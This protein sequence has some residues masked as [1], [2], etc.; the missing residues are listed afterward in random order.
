[1]IGDHRRDS[2]GLDFLGK[3]VHAEREHVHKSAQ[4]INPGWEWHRRQRSL[5]QRRRRLISGSVSRVTL[6][7]RVMAY[8]ISGNGIEGRSRCAV[9]ANESEA[10]TMQNKILTIHKLQ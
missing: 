10:V 7:R 5:S 9:A 6:R 1:M 2:G 8:G 3:I 4:Q